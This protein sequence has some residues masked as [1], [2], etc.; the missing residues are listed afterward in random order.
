MTEIF[1]DFL[2]LSY[3]SIFGLPKTHANCTRLTWQ[4]MDSYYGANTVFILVPN[5]PDIAD[6]LWH[7][8]SLLKQSG[9]ENE[10]NW[11]SS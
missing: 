3:L 10:M 6:D 9:R 7:K 2:T 4:L 8:I 11:D 1:A 5:S